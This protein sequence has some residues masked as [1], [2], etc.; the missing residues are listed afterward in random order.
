MAT[1]A[2]ELPSLARDRKFEGLYRRYAKD[3]YRYALA[4]LR[5]PDDAEDVT[6]TT[7]LNAYRA[8][9]RG[10]EPRKPQNWLIKIAHNA[11]RTRY[12]RASRRVKEVPL[13]D[14]IEQLAVAE[15]DRPDVGAVLEALG[16]LPLNQRAALVMRE[17]EGRTYA[18]IAETLGVSVAAVE[19]LI[20]RARRSLRIKASSVRVLSAVQLPASLAQLLEGG[21]VVAGGSA[22]FG[23][24][25]IFKAAIAVVAGV[26]ASS[27]GGDH[28][29]PAQA[30]PQS[31]PVVAPRLASGAEL[32]LFARIAVVA[33][34]GEAEPRS[35]PAVR[36][37]SRA[38]RRDGGR[39]SART[40]DAAPSSSAVSAGRSATP[41]TPTAQLTSTVSSVRSALP[42]STAKPTVAVP[43][44]P[45]APA[46]QLP[47][48]P[49]LPQPP[50]PLPLP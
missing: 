26:V 21:G 11:A 4:L 13:E 17:L 2:I 31:S 23:S 43:Q 41:S 38:V 5:N 36:N 9:Q 10:E 49:P 8:L 33:R 25:F 3:V 44:L 6:Q 29:G 35:R 30:A 50:A 32:R 22:L 34:P 15:E 12:Q 40:S 1:A 45:P 39:A 48:L 47:Q 19:T 7:F 16:R 24:G 28:G 14:H 37:T 46:V 18:E 20:F 42:V 27:L